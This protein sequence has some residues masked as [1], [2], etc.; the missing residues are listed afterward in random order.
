[1]SVKELRCVLQEYNVDTSKFIEKQELV[2]AVRG[3]PHHAVRHGRVRDGS[4]IV[5]LENTSVEAGASITNP[6]DNENLQ[7]LV[8]LARERWSQGWRGLGTQ[9]WEKVHGLKGLDRLAFG[10]T[11]VNLQV[12]RPVHSDASSRTTL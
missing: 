11:E 8:G 9:Y 7:R 5:T 4:L 3:V 6:A 1:M 2:D 12:P 10:H